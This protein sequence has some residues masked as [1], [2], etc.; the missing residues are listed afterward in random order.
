MISFAGQLEGSVYSK[1][2]A[3]KIYIALQPGKEEELSSSNVH[4]GKLWLRYGTT[5]LRTNHCDKQS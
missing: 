3:C 4:L 1:N 5:K 2:R